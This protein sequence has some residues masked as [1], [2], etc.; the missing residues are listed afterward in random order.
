MTMFS[1][2]IPRTPSQCPTKPCKMCKGLIMQK[3]ASK[4]YAQLPEIP[5]NYHNYIHKIW[6]CQLKIEVG[7][8]I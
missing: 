2:L 1:V 8:V 3:Y 4:E 7:L 5:N 6:N